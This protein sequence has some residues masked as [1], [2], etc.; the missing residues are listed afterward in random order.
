MLLLG[1]AGIASPIIIHLVMKQTP[2]LIPFPA[3]RFVR[4]S[5]QASRRRH[6]LKH[7]LL[8]LLRVL[9]I[10]LLATALARPILKS[11]LFTSD[12]GTPITAVFLFDD[13]YSMGYE[14]RGKTRLEAARDLAVRIIDRL[15]GQSEAV[16]M[17]SS[18]PAAD[19]TF[20]LDHV[21]RALK[22][23]RTTPVPSVCYTALDRAYEVLER[24][25]K[26]KRREIYLFTD[27]TAVGWHG[28]DTVKPKVNEEVGLYVID[29]GA[30]ENLNV[31]LTDLRL[32]RQTIAENAPLRLT[33]SV[34][35][36]NLAGKRVV[37]LFLDG[38]KKDQQEIVLQQ[39][40]T[41]Q[42]AFE[43]P[44]RGRGLHQGRVALKERDALATDDVASFTVMVTE[45]PKV[46]L[47]SGA[48]GTR[49]PAGEAFFPSSALSPP[50]LRRH[51]RA[52]V[53]V[54]VIEPA[55]LARRR[56]DDYAAVLMFNVASLP[57]QTWGRL[58][59][60]VFAGGGLGVFVGDRVKAD[61]YNG[62]G[63]KALMPGAIGGPVSPP[64]G[65]TMA[66]K[67]YGHPILDRFR[68]GAN[69]DLGAP[70]FVTYLSLTERKP[71]SRVIVPF[72]DGA[73]AL[74]EHHHGRG[75]VLF[76]A[77]T[78]SRAWTDF[79]VATEAYPIFLAQVVDRLG[80]TLQDE[81]TL[82]IGQTVR[83][84]LAP[85]QRG[86]VLTGFAPGAEVGT[87]LLAEPG[88]GAFTYPR[89][90]AVGNYRVELRRED[91]R[92]FTGFS[93]NPATEES[94]LDRIDPDAVAQQFPPDA[95]VFARSAEELDKAFAR[96][97]V[98][99]EVFPYVLLMLLMIFVCESY[100]ANRF[101][102]REGV[103][104]GEGEQG[105]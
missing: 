81:R 32:S 44:I 54:E 99:K 68:D 67:D 71:D 63:A 10:L 49:G 11:D 51:Q 2:R 75:R 50:G 38:Q 12:P 1:A 53:R 72:S 21:R 47:V 17:T 31:A 26:T 6:R 90:K 104:V 73:P 84:R 61:D 24:A 45:A 88:G 87:P 34:E 66:V 91:L 48:G 97:R 103:V 29:V 23:L 27:M 82:P 9:L 25:A 40:Q 55:D 16:I 80:G 8:L 43:Y 78:A 35:A 93:V 59:Q 70:L 69:G 41:A 18:N 39:G 58:N 64:D 52:P 101:Y 42:A 30:N 92:T 33:A 102:R 15:P 3:L 19:R 7:L 57:P 56:L 76:F 96:V 94:R 36:G 105:S 62:V 13:S 89:P 79:P 65:V 37:E 4:T 14:F 83:L 60:Y 95:I 22:D 98:G 28:I 74:V 100:L 46:L 85:E 86:A 20:S 5:H 77:S